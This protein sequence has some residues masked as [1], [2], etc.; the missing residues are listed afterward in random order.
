MKIGSQQYTK[1]MATTAV[2]LPDPNNFDLKHKVKIVTSPLAEGIQVDW[3]QC[4]DDW[5]PSGLLGNSLKD[6]TEENF[7]LDIRVGA[8][9]AGT[10]V[11]GESTNPE[12]NINL[13]GKE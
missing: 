2:L 1:R 10:F 9:K 12:L 5:I 3:F 11:A 8:F 4:D 7:H 6:E 13:D